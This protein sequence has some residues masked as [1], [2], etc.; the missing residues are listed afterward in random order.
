M[1]TQE[2]NKT[3]LAGPS[4]TQGGPLLTQPGP[5]LTHLMQIWPKSF[6]CRSIRAFIALMPCDPI[7]I[8]LSLF[9]VLL[10]YRSKVVRHITAP[11]LMVCGA[12][13]MSLSLSAPLA[14]CR[15]T[16]R[17]GAGRPLGIFA[18][19]RLGSQ[20]LHI[21]PDRVSG[22]R[23]FRRLGSSKYSWLVDSFA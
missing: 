8:P 14:T 7:G 15:F 18:P 11:A 22:F 6:L 9:A 16:W 23:I 3:Y 19:V 21:P 10:I 5:S 17:P 4:L 1:A 12:I 2:I 20:Q 13:V